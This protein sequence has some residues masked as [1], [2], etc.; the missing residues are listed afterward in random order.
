MSLERT[1]ERASS[2]TRFVG[3]FSERF[4]TLPS[5]ESASRAIKDTRTQAQ[6]MIISGRT[7]LRAELPKI[8]AKLHPPRLL[9]RKSSALPEAPFDASVTEPL[10]S[11]FATRP[12][13]FHTE[14]TVK[15]AAH[16]MLVSGAQSGPVLDE[17]GGEAHSS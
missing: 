16:R 11:Q 2:L 17:K 5:V 7:H 15:D 6:Q 10:V 3:L 14:E 12:I 8:S 9:A 1:G 13:F 4:F